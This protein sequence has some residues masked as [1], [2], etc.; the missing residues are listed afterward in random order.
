MTSL[1]SQLSVKYKRS[2]LMRKNIKV[3]YGRHIDHA[4][5][6]IAISHKNTNNMLNTCFTWI[7]SYRRYSKLSMT[8]NIHFTIVFHLIIHFFN[9][10]ILTQKFSS[11]FSHSLCS[12]SLEKDFLFYYTY[13]VADNTKTT[14]ISHIFGNVVIT[15]RVHLK[16][17]Y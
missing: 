9:L 15:G 2:S 6:C 7:I 17:K 4:K 12:V 10:M 14:K 1:L 16:L 8:N 11:I 5:S 13:Q 3:Y